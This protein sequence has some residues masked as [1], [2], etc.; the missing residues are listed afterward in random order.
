MNTKVC[1]ATQGELVKL[2]YDALG[3]LPRKKDPYNDFDEKTKKAIQ[4]QL[5]G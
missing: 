3:V 5:G 1:F 2:A 4:K